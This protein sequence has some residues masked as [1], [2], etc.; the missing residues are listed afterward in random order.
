[1]TKRLRFFIVG[2]DP[3]IKRMIEER[4]HIV[5]N[6]INDHTDGVVFTG[7]EDITPFLYGEPKLPDTHCNMLRDQRE[8]ALFKML[9][10]EVRKIGICRGGQLLNVLNGG[11][12]WQDVNYHTA[13]HLMR[14]DWQPVEEKREEWKGRHEFAMVTSTHHQ[15]M[16]PGDIGEVWASARMATRKIAARD[17]WEVNN[18]NDNAFEDAEVIHYWHTNSLCF[19]PH[20]EYEGPMECR[21]YF[22]ECVEYGIFGFGRDDKKKAA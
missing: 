7:G 5:Q 11:S 15:M 18:S 13:Q 19:Q 8:I 9:P 17:K 20:P 3:L 1:M 4:K 2:G 14:I 21:R 10:N 12:M 6:T 22:W 16:I